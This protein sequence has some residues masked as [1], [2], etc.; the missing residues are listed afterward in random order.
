MCLVCDTLCRHRYRLDSSVTCV[1]DRWTVESLVSL[2][3]TG[4]IYIA[5]IGHLFKYYTVI[6]IACMSVVER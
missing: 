1:N 5:D 3:S 4:E 6:C 2:L